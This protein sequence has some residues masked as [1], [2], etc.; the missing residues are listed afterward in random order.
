MP[1][2]LAVLFGFAFGVTL[3]VLARR[4]LLALEGGA[5]SVLAAPVTRLAV[6]F[7]GCVLL[8]I[9]ALLVACHGDWAYLYLLPSARVPSA[10]D[11]VLVLA[12]AVSVPAGVLSAAP[13]V[14]AG[15][16]WRSRPLAFL[17]GVPTAALIAATLACGTRLLTSATWAQW[18]GGF[19]RESLAQATLGRLLLWLDLVLLASAAFV[20]WFVAPRSPGRAGGG[21]RGATPYR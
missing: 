15:R 10:V 18:R 20:L 12:S 14:R 2:P 6:A 3:A 4:G 1:L 11:L 9:E 13:S 21:A 17:G 19:G 8:P 5:T 16:T 7:G